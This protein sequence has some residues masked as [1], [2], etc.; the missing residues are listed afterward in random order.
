MAISSYRSGCERARYPTD[1][2]ACVRDTVS[3]VR[4]LQVVTPATVLRGAGQRR[5]TAIR[6][7][8]G[9]PMT[10]LLYYFGCWHEAGHYL[11]GPDG[12]L[13]KETAGPWHPGNL[14]NY[15]RWVPKQGGT[16]LHHVDGW[17][18]LSMSDRSVDTR[19]GSHAMFL[20]PGTKT[21]SEIRQ[22]ARIYYPLPAGRLF[23]PEPDALDY[24]QLDP[25]IVETV[26]RLRDAGFETT[27][28]GDGVSKIP[29]DRV[30]DIAHVFAT[31][32]LDKM[33][34]EA[35]RMASVLGQDWR[36]EASWSPNDS[37]VAATCAILAAYRNP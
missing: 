9:E 3:A 4:D 13:C 19:P 14:D 16:Q 34:T 22:L 25:G 5:R 28:S 20:G 7:G 31:V 29:Q 18:L 8:Q 35:I 2:P 36:V 11:R 26:K 32:R 6:P 10:A 17:T 37:G 27:D 1:L 30:M 24:S 15:D 33:M 23:G 12:K 21:E